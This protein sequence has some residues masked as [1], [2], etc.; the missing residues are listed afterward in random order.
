MKRAFA[1]GEDD[2]FHR[3]RIRVKNLYYELQFLLPVWP[4]RLR[5]MTAQLKKVQEQIGDDHD[6]TVLKE[7]LQKAP[8]RFGGVAAIEPVLRRLQKSSRKLRRAGQPLAAE[9]FAEK[10]RH[11]SR[12]LDRHWA[13]W[14]N[15]MPTRRA[16]KVIR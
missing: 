14:Q 2:S 15:E 10:P 16:A 1:R 5:P 9:I 7:V 13:K 3:W 8:R 4:K 11:F 6:L 12:Q